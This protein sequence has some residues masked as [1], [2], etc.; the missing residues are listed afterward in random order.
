MAHPQANLTSHPPGHG[1]TQTSSGRYPGPGWAVAPASTPWSI[2][3]LRQAQEF[4]YCCCL[5]QRSIVSWGEGRRINPEGRV[6]GYTV[7]KGQHCPVGGGGVVGQLQRTCLTVKSL[8]RW[9]LCSLRPQCRVTQSL[10]K[11]RSCSVLTRCSPRA[12]SIPSDRYG[13]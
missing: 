7:K 12:R 10:W 4:N 11:S 3:G 13:S 6:E 8:M 9:W 1:L 2:N 5:G